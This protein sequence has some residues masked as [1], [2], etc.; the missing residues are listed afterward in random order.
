MVQTIRCPYNQCD[1]SGVVMVN[2]WTVKECECEKDKRHKFEVQKLFAELH[3]P[4][5]YQNKTLEN[6]DETRLTGRAYDMAVQYVKR[7]DEL[8]HENTNGIIFVGP[9]G[10][11]KTHLAYGILNA[12]V[13]HVRSAICGSV[14]DL[15]EMLRP[16]ADKE[17]GEK[18]LHALKTSDLVV[19]DDLGAEQESTWVTERLFMIL[20][21]RYNE[22]LPTIIT[23][24][25]ELKTLESMTG[26]ARV[27]S[28]I[29]E[30][31]YAVVCDGTDQRKPKKKG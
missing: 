27:G 24:N 21:A 16:K 31:C 7:F 20:N 29:S 30:M 23:S 1:G 19:L 28:R 13:P 2:A 17:L 18:R 15:M 4:K 22:Q 11:G 12:L 3:V 8:R 14:P 5:R 6:F 25:V 10:T 26:W 9:T